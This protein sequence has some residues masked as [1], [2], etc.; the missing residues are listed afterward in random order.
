M[1]DYILQI[2]GEENIYSLKNFA[3]SN[4]YASPEDLKWKFVI[5]VSDM[6]YLGENRCRFQRITDPETRKHSCES[7]DLIL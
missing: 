5:K 6:F 7:E 2:L 1:A 4:H 3:S